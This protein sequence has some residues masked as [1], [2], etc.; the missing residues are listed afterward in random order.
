[1]KGFILFWLLWLP[2]SALTQEVIVN[3]DFNEQFKTAALR[4]YQIDQNDTTLIAEFDYENNRVTS[5][6]RDEIVFPDVETMKSSINNLSIFASFVN[7]KRWATDQK[8][9]D[10]RYVVETMP[11]NIHWRLELGG[12]TTNVRFNK[13]NSRTT[14][15]AREAIDYSWT[16][17]K[18]YL[19]IYENHFELLN[20]LNR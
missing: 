7:E 3:L 11:T 9:S 13:N 15:S 12:A 2:A 17:F 5:P 16:D 19:H 4:Y 18:F 20:F 8:R 14:I 10:Y 1:M 6:A